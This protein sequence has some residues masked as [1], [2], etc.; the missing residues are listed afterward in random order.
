M[1]RHATA[2]ITVAA[3]LLLSGAPAGADMILDWDSG[4][5]LS[6]SP[7]FTVLT[8]RQLQ[9]TVIN[10]STAIPPGIAR[11]A[12]SQF[13][14]S[15]SFDL[16][17]EVQI[18]GGSALLG[19]G[20]STVNFDRVEEQLLAGADVSA[21]WGFSNDGEGMD[22]DRLVITTLKG[23]STRAFLTGPNLDGPGK[24]NGPQ[25]G[26]LSDP[27]LRDIGNL[28]GI[29]GPVIFTLE[30]DR[31]IDISSPWLTGGTLE[32]GNN[33][34]FLSGPGVAGP[35]PEPMT[36]GLLVVGGLFLAAGSPT[37]RRLLR[38]LAD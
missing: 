32:F 1:N 7:E 30:L 35:A 38:R 17:E 3:A 26:L 11:K 9:V 15:I 21:E 13:L 16:P 5:G 25:G 4:D 8:P 28:G 34:A 27:L 6:A 19:P 2:T 18:V 29:Q 12:R 37:G 36:S 33:A 31:D 14:T 24:L 10:T 22:L 20:A 23:R